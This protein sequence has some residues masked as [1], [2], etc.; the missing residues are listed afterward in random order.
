MRE[1]CE[2]RIHEEFAH[3]LFAPDEGV[4]LGDSIRKV[5]IQTD[6]P[7]F[8]RIGVLRKKLKV[9]H[10]DSFFS[11]WTLTHRYGQKELAAAE[12]F[13]LMITAV[14]EPEGESCGT[15]YDYSAACPEC[16]MPRTLVG[17]LR[18]DLRKVPK[19]K[20]IA[21]TIADDEW[22]VSQR[23]AELMVDA[24]LTGF[25]LRP[26]RH[27]A[28]YEDD[29]L[30]L[31]T[32]PSGRELLRRAE[33]AGCPHPT[34]RFWC[35]LNRPE[36]Q[37]LSVQATAEYVERCE[38]RVRR[39]G[40]RLPAWH[41]LVITSHPVP[42]LPPTRFGVDPFDDDPE[43][44]Y[45]CRYG[46][47]AGLNLLSE[48]TVSREGWDGSDVCRTREL[49]GWPRRPGERA[50]PARVPAPVVLISPR[51]RELLVENNVKGFRTE[52]AYLR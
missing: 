2:F 50:Y 47:V 48:V 4:R 36:Q 43:G 31:S 14:F 30:D 44:N 1:E 34:G 45:R 12:L 25:D 28:R 27:K 19:K 5:A 18:L 22:I 33:D 39:G 37:E 26:V 9:T 49:I 3:L 7:R 32:V 23:L 8:P 6:D 16:G 24:K 51:F 20:D 46:H 38:R 40:K 29:P 11:G 17:D 15:Q 52:V 42:T 35:W 10:N 21:A 13:E 41:Q